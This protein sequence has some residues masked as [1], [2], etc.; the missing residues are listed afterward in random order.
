MKLDSLYET[1]AI[2]LDVDADKIKS[3]TTSEDIEEWDSI[4]H[5]SILVALDEKLDG[6]ISKIKEFAEADTIE[7]IVNLLKL[8]KLIK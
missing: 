3:K 5:L 2:A 4:G 6:K 8:N 1:I 7:K